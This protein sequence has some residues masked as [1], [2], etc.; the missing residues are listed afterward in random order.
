MSIIDSIYKLDAPQKMLMWKTMGKDSAFFAEIIKKDDPEFVAIPDCHKLVYDAYDRQ[1]NEGL[2]RVCVVEP[3]GFG[4]S[5]KKILK[6]LQDIC[7]KH[8][9]VIC[10]TSESS[11]QGERDLEALR[12]SLYTN[13][14]INALYGNLKGPVDNTQKIITAND[15][16]VCAVGFR[17]RIRG[18]H[19]NNVR[20]TK[21][22]ADDFESEA[23]SLS[24]KGREDVQRRIGSQ[25]EPAGMQAKGGGFRLIFLGTIIHP[26]TYLAKASENEVF[27]KNHNGYYLKIDLSTDMVNIG[28]PNWKEWFPK[29]K[30]EELRWKYETQGRLWEFYQE[31]YGVPHLLSDPKFDITQIKEIGCKFGN[32]EDLT[33]I[34]HNGT[35]IPINVF[36][37]ID[38]AIGLKDGSD[39]TIITVLGVMPTGNK[40]LLD[41][42]SGKIP[43]KD[44]VK[45]VLKLSDKYQPQQIT[46]E[47]YGYQLELSRHIQ[48]KMMDRGIMF[49]I[50]NYQENIKKSKKFLEGLSPMINDGKLSYIESC[51]N[52]KQFLHEASLY[53]GQNSTDRRKDDTLD[54]LFLANNGSYVPQLYDVDKEI[55][56]RRLRE[57]N[58]SRDSGFE[59]FGNRDWRV[60]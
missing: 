42:Y 14:I 6:T 40:I 26:L 20:L 23:N 55:R 15:I 60:A 24:D 47:T 57:H 11:T 58:F 53:S 2:E 18:I 51:P 29:K 41:M 19:Y 25:L 28:T 8:E 44:Q 50:R 54:G 21:A 3:R 13:T 46:V 48:D 1:T 45:E 43:M 56:A 12:N 59:E 33:W 10:F 34:E 37:G 27:T 9:R 39:N 17:S 22:W 4:K 52:V 16:F 7:Y 30:I 49:P 5:T 31:Y 38:P 35:K 32:Y 36:I